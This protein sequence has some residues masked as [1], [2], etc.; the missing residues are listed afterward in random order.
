MDV[1]SL[2]RGGH[3]WKPTKKGWILNLSNPQGI[4]EASRAV[5]NEGKTQC[6]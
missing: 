4:L 3:Y 6:Q 1:Y 5:E 2:F